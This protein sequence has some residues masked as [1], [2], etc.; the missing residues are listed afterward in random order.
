MSSNDEDNHR[1]TAAQNDAD[2]VSAPA[3]AAARAAMGFVVFPHQHDVPVAP[4][5]H[6]PS[7]IIA[8]RSMEDAIDGPSR[9]T[10]P[11][12]PFDA[13]EGLDLDSAMLMGTTNTPTTMENNDDVPPRKKITYR[14]PPPLVLSGGN[15]ST[16][17]GMHDS[18]HHGGRY[19]LPAYCRFVPGGV[20]FLPR[21]SEVKSTTTTEDDNN[22]YVN[23]SQHCG[24]TTKT[25]VSMLSATAT[26]TMTGGGVTSPSSAKS[27]RLTTATS[28][29]KS[30]NRRSSLTVDT[31]TNNT[32]ISANGPEV[33]VRRAL[34]ADV[35]LHEHA[36]RYYAA[37]RRAAAAS[38]NSDDNNSDDNNEDWATLGHRLPSLSHLA[39]SALVHPLTSVHANSAV[40]WAESMIMEY[41]DGRIE[42]LFD[43]KNDD[44]AAATDDK[45]FVRLQ[46]M[47]IE[48]ESQLLQ[49]EEGKNSNNDDNYAHC[50]L[51]RRAVL[52]AWA[53]EEATTGRSPT[54]SNNS[55]NGNN[56]SMPLSK[57]LTMELPTLKG[58]LSA[59]WRVQRGEEV[60]T[61]NNGDHN[62]CSPASSKSNAFFGSD[63]NNDVKL[64]TKHAC[65]YE[66][67]PCGYVFRRGDIAW[68]CRT[69]QTDA[70]CVLC[71][72][73]FRESDHVGHEVF[74]HRTTPGGCCDCGD[75]EAWN[76]DGMCSRHRPPPLT[77]DMEDDGAKIDDFAFAAADAVAGWMGTDDD[78]EAVRAARRTR[79]EHE[80]HVDGTPTSN[81]AAAD[82]SELR[83]LPPRLAAAM[84]IV[85]GSAIQSILTAAEGSAIGA[86]VSQWR[87]RWA[88]EI[89]KLW[90][91]VS[92]DEEYYIRG[93]VLRSVGQSV[94]YQGD[95]W[96]HPRHVLDSHDEYY[97]NELPQSYSLFLRLHNDDVHTFEEV[98]K[99]LHG[100]NSEPIQVP[101]GGKGS[102]GAI[103]GAGITGDELRARGNIDR[104]VVAMA[105][106]GNDEFSDLTQR[107]RLVY[108][109]ATSLMDSST[110]SDHSQPPTILNSK[111]KLPAMQ[112]ASEVDPMAPLV[113]RIDAAQDL[114]RKVDADGQVIVR[115][116]DTI[117]GAAIG[118]SRLRE[119]SGLHC[120]VTTTARIQSEER[121]K[122]LLE[123]LTGLI[124]SHPAVSAMIVHCIVD[125]TEGE[126][127]LCSTRNSNTKS[128]PGMSRGVAV[129]TAPRM[130]PCWSG[131]R[132]ID[133]V[134]GWRRRMD[135]FPPHLESS[136][137][138]REECRELFRL[139]MLSDDADTFIGVTGVDPNFYADVPYSLP[140]LR[141]RKSP[142]ALWGSLPASHLGCEEVF[143]HRLL[144]ILVKS[145]TKMTGTPNE[146][147][148]DTSVHLQ[149][150]VFIVDTDL[151][152]HEEGEYLTSATYPYKMAGL[153]MISGVG[154]ID[155]QG[156]ADSHYFA[157]KNVDVTS[158]EHAKQLVS[159][160]SFVA[161]T[162]PVLTMLLLDPYSP[163]QLRS[164]LH[165]LF[166]RLL[167]DSRF[168]SRFAAS[169]GAV[170]Y[171]PTSTL[172]CA[173]IG[174]DAD[175]LLGFTVQLFT[176]GS[177][178]KALGN[179]D[180]VK[181]LLC[182]EDK[183]ANE[184]EVACVSAVPI[185]HLVVR[186][187]H[188]NILGATKEVS[189]AV[190]N[191]V[192]E[193]A[194]MQQSSTWSGDLFDIARSTM[195]PSLVYQYGT[196][197]PLNTRLPGAPDDKYI[198][199][200]C[201]K[202]K[203]VPHLL[204]D[205][206]YIY[207]T[208]GT[209]M[210]LLRS[211]RV[212][213]ANTPS[214]SPTAASDSLF[215]S[216]TPTPSFTSPT[217]SLTN[218]LST[219]NIPNAL[220]FPS[221]WTR[222]LRLGQGI[223]LQKRRISGG[224]VEFEDERWL[225]AYALSLNLGNTSDAL[226]ES[227]FAGANYFPNQSS[228][229]ASIRSVREANR[230]AMG[231]L[232]SAFFK[233]IKLWLYREGLLE[234]AVARQTSRES[235]ELEALQRSTLHVSITQLDESS[236]S[237]F[238]AGVQLAQS[239]DV[240]C[241]NGVKNLPENKLALLEAAM[242]H[243][244]T[245]LSQITMSFGR[246]SSHG[247]VM[248]DWLKV[249]HSPLAGDCFSFHI[250]LH[251]ALA[252]SIVCFCSVV[253]PA[254]ERIEMPDTWWRLPILDQDDD[255]ASDPAYD[256]S[257][258]QDS[259][260]SLLRS[261][262][263]TSNFRVVWSSGPECSTPE[264]Q[265]RK[266]RARLLSA[267]LAST[268]VVHS[269]CDHPLR[270]IISAQQIDH[271]MWAK[272]GGSL[273]SMAMN[274]GSVP[275]CRSLRDLDLVMV[276]LSASGF[277]IGLGSR[278][279]F[280]LLS[281]RFSLDG[282]LC[283]PDRRSS[284]GKDCWVKP[285][286]MQE[287]E[288]AELLAESFFTTLCILVSDLPA[289]PPLSLND[290]SVLR[291]NLRREVLHALAVEPRSHSEALSAASAAVSRRD[292]N[293]GGQVGP[294]GATSFR[295]IFT[296][297]LHSIGQQRN[298][299]SRATG[300]PT[301]ELKPEGS[302]E[303]DP[304]FY[305]LRKTEH[306]HAMDNIAR[307]RRQKLGSSSDGRAPM[308]V[309]PL[310]ATPPDAHPRFVACRL[311]L[312]IPS[313]YASIRRYLMYVLFN[314]S[315]LPPNKPELDEM[316]VANDSGHGSVPIYSTDATMSL[317][318]SRGTR[319][320]PSFSP[321]TVAASSK[322]F[323]EVLHI[324]TLQV[325][326]L[327]ECSSLH[328]ALPFLD[329]EHKILS[330][331]ININSYL[332]QLIS[333]PTHLIN[334]WS[335]QAAPVG[336]LPSDGSG[337]N[338]GSVLGLLIAL[339][340]HRDNAKSTGVG[341]KS[342]NDDHGGARV[343]SADGLKWLLRFISALVGG[344]VSV[345]AAC[346]SATSGVPVVSTSSDNGIDPD[347][348][349]V[350]KDMLSNLPELWP[351][352][353]IGSSDDSS[354]NEMN[355]KSKEV[356]KAA[357]NRALAKMKKL[358]ISFAASIASQ[359]TSATE[360]KLFDDNEENLCIICKC[361]DADGDN[362][363][364]GYLGH[365][366][367]SRVAQLASKSTL[368]EYCVSKNLDLNSIHRVVGEKGC[369]VRLS[370]HLSV[371]T[372]R[373]L[374]VI[375]TK[376]IY[377]ACFTQLRST[378]LIDSAPLA[379]LPKGTI[380]EV[381][382]SKVS[383]KLCLLSRR[384]LVRRVMPD[385]KNAS[386]DVVQGWASIQS[387]QGY[388]ILSP[389]SSL[390]YTNTRWGPTRPI[391]R[392]CGHAA[393]FHCVEAHCLSLHQR[394]AG[395]QPFDGRFSANI[396]DGEFLCP[397]CKQLSNILIPE[398]KPV[399]SIYQ[400]LPTSPSSTDK[401][402][403][404]AI[405][406]EVPTS[407]SSTMREDKEGFEILK[408][409][410][411]ASHADMTLIR[412]ILERTSA[413]SYSET[414][415]KSDKATLQFGSSLSQAMQLSSENAG[416]TKKREKDLH[417]ALRR[418]DFEDDDQ[419]E[420]PQI[421][422]TLRL[423]RQLL[424]SWAA[425]GHSAAA[426]EASGRSSRKV[427]FGETMFTTID[428]WSDFTSKERDSHPM[429]LELRRTMAA[430]ASLF[431]SVTFEMAKQ[432]G[433]DKEKSKGESVPIFGSLICDILDG[434]HWVVNTCK[435]PSSDDWRVVTSIVNSMLCHVSKG[436]AIAQRLE[437]RAVATSMWTILGSPTLAQ[438]SAASMNVDPSP[439]VEVNEEGHIGNQDAARLFDA[440]SS[441]KEGYSS[442][443]RPV[444]PPKP[445][446]IH[447]TERNLAIEID[448]M[449]GTLDP[450]KVKSN[451]H[452][453][454]PFRPA[455]A[456]AFLYVPLLAWDLNILAGAVFSTLLSTKASLDP[457]VSCCELLHSARVLLI[458]RLIQ[459]LSTPNGFLT[460]TYDI[461]NDDYDNEPHWDEKKK[462][463]EADAIKELLMFCRGTLPGTIE[464]D[465]QDVNDE[466]L[467]QNIGNAILPFGRTLILLLRSSSSAIRQ[468]NR[469]NIKGD[470]AEETQMDKFV[471]QICENPNTMTTEDG[472]W[473][474]DI[475]GAPM[476]SS[477]LTSSWSSLVKRWLTCLT[478][479]D[480]Y[481]GTRGNGLTFNEKTSSWI[482][483]KNESS[484]R[485]SPPL[486]NLHVETSAAAVE[487]AQLPPQGNDS[488][489]DEIDSDEDFDGEEEEDSDEISFD[490][491]VEDE[492]MEFVDGGLVAD[493]D[494]EHDEALVESDVDMDVD[495][496]DDFYD[497]GFYDYFDIDDA[498]DANAA[499]SEPDGSKISGPMDH[500]FA[501]VSRSAIVPYQPSVLGISQIG[502]GPRG[503]R[504]ELF[505]Y[506]VANSIMRDMSHLG[507]IHFPGQPM[508]CLVMLP[509]SFVELYSMVNRVKG[510]D[511]QSDDNDE[512]GSFETA[513][514]LLTG[515]VMRS[516][517]I[518]RMKENR[519]PGTCTLHARK[520]GSGL[521]IFFLV[522]KCTILLMHNNK[523]AYS[524]S[525]YVDEHGEEDVGLRRGRPLFFSEERYQALENL[526]R[527]HGLPR[528]VSQIRSTSDRVIRDNWY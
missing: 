291:R 21:N 453:Q 137:L 175:T 18:T 490:E 313:M 361:D 223:D 76:V 249:P 517:T 11:P 250:P 319:N 403:F 25:D 109:R 68:N 227:S 280:S 468:R 449:W 164:C 78:F 488:I 501:F 427:S 459:V 239:C 411:I 362:G 53:H 178:V 298:Q 174:T 297:V 380:V 366:Q 44:G 398:D 482:P 374:A 103:G 355:D 263:K 133:G 104:A 189:L 292:E 166:L 289:P 37:D 238:F 497:S 28:P 195:P 475:I 284:F 378:E 457:C 270:C 27:P 287:P 505:E 432:L 333:V 258:K 185:S 229:S 106:D 152:K 470:I 62:V 257:F 54:N 337:K 447:R 504:G 9:S 31:T 271:H 156:S 108:R 146:V 489:N 462:R 500:M 81:V 415:S 513:I 33:I 115:M 63:N 59:C 331:S 347:I 236:L 97:V 358:Q 94:E 408:N 471:A 139:G 14:A 340:E 259:L 188:A 162:S 89:C 208:P 41:M 113:S 306:Q 455:V 328:Q 85:I 436:D 448:P 10:R 212:L 262:Y 20:A 120:G 233:E 476:P 224:H 356:Q 273:A 400:V 172:F 130:M 73:C 423:M 525:L 396:D 509:K 83:P 217:N 402:G 312:H 248:G 90:N 135:A 47:K 114:T 397:L 428:P 372:Q 123:W 425:V 22:G 485:Y 484:L 481:H 282:Y 515:A 401:E 422:S 96:A 213:E 69:C 60:M 32:G 157:R 116:Y 510:R 57:A 461:D 179:L 210:K 300:A 526:W 35:A 498:S 24:T 285:P 71:D 301:F 491:S 392:Q 373:F 12:T 8:N 483:I 105:E 202:H 56:Q 15:L 5:M 107:Q 51:L 308:M 325:H 385:G 45:E 100:R 72:N 80:R 417:P 431:D 26:A 290:D 324:L 435:N 376:Y 360:K 477:V 321:E 514:C 330:S 286:R 165:S 193:L 508:N 207:E 414:L 197:H 442:Q 388:V 251:R 345:K 230:E 226:A 375:I 452:N 519:P 393:H 341:Q 128:I 154:Y 518:R 463:G 131:T 151:R 354:L 303:Y 437:A 379:L 93:A 153:N 421:G 276:Q 409:D 221:V 252:R 348:R 520:V 254:D 377:Y 65:A 30:S 386:E 359:S 430:T 383:P 88:D 244:R 315:W 479:F 458:G 214:A 382:E 163:K 98:I 129:W 469:R 279:V 112:Y 247:P 523:S 528:E 140:D 516:G 272:N 492:V 478:G 261:T 310:V 260:S 410:M 158:I 46:K 444:L 390:C 445:L 143:T 124:G 17:G 418:W 87:L 122:A 387:W 119:S 39:N 186:S 201:M 283:D 198:D 394:S 245:K 269:L 521:G 234:T 38:S 199:S 493:S 110:S 225:G 351:G 302:H 368:R 196:E 40:K 190:Q 363:P 352:K 317:R 167:T 365:V 512:D 344:A 194:D 503:S 370:L 367:R 350:V 181:A 296:E 150:K 34:L 275:L 391:I 182:R 168:K 480:T 496:D 278:R 460:R 177:L 84:S 132:E 134:V 23:L 357:Q 407:S 145:D 50:Q 142:H 67:G 506:N 125:I 173:G 95:V 64:V 524:P 161:P 203:R 294:G 204:R 364:M 242:L 147:T 320:A 307:L 216:L 141:L 441:R 16:I 144:R 274:Y 255:F 43:S 487:V 206:E 277:N 522:Q 342:V 86:D 495:V 117:N 399:E 433:S 268:K 240:A 499:L 369:Q 322:S 502:P 473:L 55:S 438:L 58:L 465:V 4:I 7:N 316:A 82:N 426:S 243:E 527:N 52:S 222:L 61:T 420:G 6:A 326:T 466:S 121:A 309:L 266:S 381:L 192:N 148:D 413:V 446:S 346:E 136:Y 336:P 450:F 507:S 183:V 404:E 170:V 49:E 332:G 118:F 155:Q 246:Y 180:A 48:F 486:K 92:D 412:N 334:V 169:L 288:H 235:G 265:L 304:S 281:N 187:I 440:S 318:S 219:Y 111:G 472:F 264:A 424:I 231:N 339:Y 395:N 215:D 256:A 343:L 209:A 389:I 13:D 454:I 36:L 211:G 74:F 138:T 75:L 456:S 314:G 305:H 200:R 91:G 237:R 101:V 353:D 220:D 443:P 295:A 184:A 464:P 102:V 66:G 29:S 205:L 126:D 338:R 19:P 323:L 335:L 70:T 419:G 159:C 405:D 406:P 42:D 311:L 2:D 451:G 439:E 149:S 429:L 1:R 467:L 329:H 267:L 241:E 253:V 349:A 79:L 127:V 99:A 293:D 371:M 511:S 191:S 327:D 77:T 232:F 160:S 474:L 171:R 434:K 299:G 176:T 218:S 416:A 3:A 494:D 384:V 228:M